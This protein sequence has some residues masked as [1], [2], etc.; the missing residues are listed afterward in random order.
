MNQLL[1]CPII[2]LTHEFPEDLYV[3]RHG[4]SGKYG[5]YCHDG[6]HGLACFSTEAG[7]IQFG[8]WIDMVGMK[9]EEVKF[10]QAREIAKC[11]P[12]PIVSL[13]LLDDLDQPQVHFIR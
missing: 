1:D 11:R 3:I 8:H 5:C 4:P 10:D 9:P 2:G 12:M 13:M 6:V 7:A